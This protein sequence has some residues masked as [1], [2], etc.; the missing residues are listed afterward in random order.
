MSK[1]K[2][3]AKVN[4]MAKAGKKEVDDPKHGRN[5][6]KFTN[7]QLHSFKVKDFN[8]DKNNIER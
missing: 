6:P 1:R 7:K 5:C 2:L 4:A 3:L 8:Y